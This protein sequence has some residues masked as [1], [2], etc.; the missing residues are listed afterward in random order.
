MPGKLGR[1]G[2]YSQRGSARDFE[3]WLAAGY[4]WA[5]ALNHDADFWQPIQQRWGTKIVVRSYFGTQ[6]LDPAFAQE[7]ADAICRDAD[8]LRGNGVSVEAVMGLNEVGLTSVEE[9]KRL[10]AL[11]MAM[12]PII[13]GRGYQYACGSQAVTW[14]KLEHLPVYR[15]VLEASDYWKRHEYDAPSM[16]SNIGRP[17]YNDRV[18]YY[19]KLYAEGARLGI[20]MPPLIIGE[21]GIDGGVIDGRLRGFRAFPATD[22]FEDLRWYAGELAKDSYV[23]AGIIFIVGGFADWESF[24]VVGTPVAVRLETATF[25]VQESPVTG[26][27]IRVL[28][29]DWTIRTVAVEDYLRGVVPNEMPA[30]WPMEA[31]KAQA[32]AARTYAMWRIANPR[33]STYDVY[34]DARDQMYVPAFTHASTDAAVMA[35]AGLTWPEGTGQYVSKCGR[36]ECPLCRGTG[37]YYGQTYPGRF[38]QYGAKYMADQGST[39]R[40]ILALYY[41]NGQE[42]PVAS[43]PEIKCYDWQGNPITLAALQAK[44]KIVVR[45][46]EEKGAVASGHEVFRVTALR[47]KAGTTAVIARCL[48]ADGSADAGRA[49][50]GHWDG[51]PAR[52][53]PGQWESNYEVGATNALGEVAA[54]TMGSGGVIGPDGGPHS[55]WVVSPSTLSDCVDKIGW[56]GGTDHWHVDPQFTLII[57]QAAEST[58]DETEEPTPFLEN[59]R[60]AGY[61][62]AGVAYNPDAA[63]V[64][65]A[66][67]HRL[68]AALGNESEV[69]GY[70]VQPFRDKILYVMKG[71][72]GNVQELDW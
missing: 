19:R 32:V 57:Q 14:P 10:A 72:W 61:N 59:I 20:D 49:V 15:P 9:V 53:V 4:G 42:E 64:R 39:Y 34:S 27:Q 58:E 25:A 70:I 24:D 8:R 44:Y 33:T 46:A 69:Q 63:L 41:G 36:E 2:G 65:Y 51:A 50:A 28:M 67:E 13:R 29:P 7:Y 66:Q 56:D 23:A 71:D 35:T 55:V 21:C 43:Y 6:H 60:N 30:T 47:E 1:L 5:V 52:D 17:G 62:A 45:R 3:H 54:I 26:A 11:E 38:C 37:G 40:D 12:L 68:G 18:L 48:L 22:Y 16:R 31:L